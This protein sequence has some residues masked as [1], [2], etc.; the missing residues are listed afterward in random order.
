[1]RIG[2]NTILGDLP[3]LKGENELIVDNQDVN[4][5]ISAVIESHKLFAKDYDQ[6][7]PYFYNDDVKNI[8]S[9]LFNF[10]K[11]SIPYVEESDS[12][13]TVK[14]PAAILAFSDLSGG[15]CKHYASFIGGVLDAINRNTD[16]NIKWIYRFAS[17]NLF[18]SNPGHV[19]VVVNPGRNEIWVDPVL[20]TL[21]DRSQTPYSQIDKKPK[22]SIGRIGNTEQTAGA[23]LQKIAPALAAIPVVGIF[24]AVGAEVAGTVLS[25]FGIKAHTMSSDV[26]G[27]WAYYQIN[28]AGVNDTYGN[29]GNVNINQPQAAV[30]QAWFSQV[31]GVPIYDRQRFLVLAGRYP[32][33]GLNVPSNNIFPTTGNSSIFS[34]GHRA[35]DLANTTAA[36][37]IQLYHAFGGECATV[38]DANILGA[39]PIAEKMWSTFFDDSKP[40]SAT[41][42]R[43]TWAYLPSAPLL[44]DPSLTV[45]DSI[46]QA[47][48]S[49][50]L[51]SSMSSPLMWLLL[52]GG[53]YLLLSGSGK[54]KVSGMNKN[55]TTTILLIGAGAA[56]IYFLTKK[57]ATTTPVNSIVVGDHTGT[58]NPFASLISSISNIFKSTPSTGS[59]STSDDYTSDYDVIQGA[60]D[61][62]NSH[63]S[64]GTPT[65]YVDPNSLVNAGDS[66]YDPEN[67]EI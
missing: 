62:Y 6:I 23:V 21:D 11:K 29:L 67:Y 22:S 4:D 49:N 61:Y 44:I 12:Q 56:A 58:T 34:L 41:N 50:S 55:T 20:S 27:L 32:T 39:I 42:Q 5:I 9:S 57:P 26:R 33:D 65:Y 17:Y 28:V 7:W 25:I 46:V 66:A 40:V 37:R 53:G 16:K 2:K 30:A 8:C 59:G 51:T 54:K 10:C 52:A 13:Q 48:A 45:D 15:D 60:E 24:A 18:D 43:G 14:S 35:G 38:P 31:L 19:F 3:P 63:N 47:A 36:Q 1:M 64:F